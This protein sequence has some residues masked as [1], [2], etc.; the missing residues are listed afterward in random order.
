MDPGELFLLIAGI[1]GGAIAG[2]W[3]PHTH[4]AVIALVRNRA[5]ERRRQLE[6]SG[7]VRE[8]LVN[9]YESRQLSQLLFGCTIGGFE[10]R[11]PFLTKTEWITNQPILID[12]PQHLHFS[13]TSHPT[14]PINWSLIRQRQR[15]GQRLFNEPTL[16][17]DRLHSSGDGVALHVKPC[18]Y[19]QMVSS[20]AGL[21]EE[22]FVAITQH[23]APTPLR[24]RLTRALMDHITSFTRWDVSLL[25]LFARRKAMTCC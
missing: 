10:V 23:H 17:L 9:Y 24:D 19:Y 12:G 14:V 6:R 7:R 16:Y 2:H 8:W 5:I 4:N 13:E 18:D 20:L 15:F 21:E 25:Y 3:Y 22:T 1:I 11:I